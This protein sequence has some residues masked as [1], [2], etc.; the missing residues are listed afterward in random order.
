MPIVDPITIRAID[1]PLSLP[2]FGDVVVVMLPEGVVEWIVVVE[3]GVVEVVVDAVVL[4][5][6]VVDVVF[7]VVVVDVVVGEGGGEVQPAW[8]WLWGQLLCWSQWNCWSI[9]SSSPLHL[10]SPQQDLKTVS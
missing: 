2:C 7:D 10:K 5:F 9:H 6:G 3:C 1:P 4:A 8:S